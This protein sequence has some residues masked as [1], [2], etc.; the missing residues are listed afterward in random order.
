M[1]LTYFTVSA[2]APQGAAKI[3]RVSF[4]LDVIRG[5]RVTGYDLYK[6]GLLHGH[7]SGGA[8]G[9]TVTGVGGFHAHNHI[10]GRAS[11]A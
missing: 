8:S 3:T 2:Q 1:D 10:S 6:V 4:K 5:H 9:R 11:H 7:I